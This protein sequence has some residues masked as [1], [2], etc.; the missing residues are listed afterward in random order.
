MRVPRLKFLC[1]PRT[2]AVWHSVTLVIYGV[3]F[4]EISVSIFYA[5][6]YGL[7]H[8]RPDEEVLR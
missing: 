5:E 6:S 4:E 7:R 3:I 8:L 1:R 2:R